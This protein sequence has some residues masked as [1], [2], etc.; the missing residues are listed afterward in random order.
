MTAKNYRQLWQNQIV[1]PIYLNVALVTWAGK[2]MQV[3]LRE[4]NENYFEKL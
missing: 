3:P 1:Y 4:I 2:N